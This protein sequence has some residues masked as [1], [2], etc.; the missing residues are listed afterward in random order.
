MA[1]SAARAPA[2]PALSPAPAVAAHRDA[3]AA[4]AVSCRACWRGHTPSFSFGCSVNFP[5][6]GGCGSVVGTPPRSAG[7]HAPPRTIARCVLSA[8]TAKAPHQP[9]RK[10][11][12]P[13]QS[14]HDSGQPRVQ[15]AAAGTGH[16]MYRICGVDDGGATARLGAQQAARGPDD[17]LHLGAVA[18][19]RRHAQCAGSRS[20]ST[21]CRQMRALNLPMRDSI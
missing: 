4:W 9:S 16:A 18:A 5:C 2:A 6:S 13:A 15:Q 10:V 12:T 1:W 20:S 21:A 19:R 14:R 7:A 17:T 3:G 8:A 11:S